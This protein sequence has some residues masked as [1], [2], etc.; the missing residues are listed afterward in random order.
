MRLYLAGADSTGIQCYQALEQIKNYQLLFSYF[1]IKDRLN[2]IDWATQRNVPLFLDSGAFSAMH[3][4][5]SID[6]GQYCD[7]IFEHGKK[8]EKIAQLDEIGDWRGTARNLDYMRKRGLDPI[9]VFHT[10][11]PFDW[12]DELLKN[13]YLCL[14]VTGSKLRQKEIIS[15]L[16]KVFR[17]R[18]EINP[19]C[20]IH[21]FALTSSKIMKYFDWDTCDSTSW[22]SVGRFSRIYHIEKNELKSYGRDQWKYIARFY[23]DDIFISKTG[24]SE[25]VIPAW[26]HNAETILQYVEIVNKLR[27]NAVVEETNR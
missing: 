13:D 11:E 16:V 15:W 9:P 2:R 18:E 22:L 17:H 4:G 7:F 24:S 5:A 1:Y 10:N 8:F 14:G 26:K 27:R 25:R 12:L 6:I 20:K 23:N 19:S 3:S 21:G